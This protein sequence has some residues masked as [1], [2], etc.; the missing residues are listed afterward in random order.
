M[1][2]VAVRALARQ[3]DVD[4]DFEVAA[5][6]VVALI[7]ENGAGKSTVL[8]MIAGLLRPDSGCVRSGSRVL[9][10]TASNVFVPPHA[11]RIGLLLQD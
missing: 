5:G 2:G 11:R 8:H 1:T 9:T 6:E 4:V 7:G 3:R 10:D